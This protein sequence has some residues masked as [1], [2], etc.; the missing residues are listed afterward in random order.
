MKKSVLRTI[1]ACLSTGLLISC[2]GENSGGGDDEGLTDNQ[3][4]NTYIANNMSNYYYWNDEVTIPSTIPDDDPSEFFEELVYSGD[5]FSWLRNE[6]SGSTKASRDSNSYLPDKYTD[7]FGYGL[8]YARFT[9]GTYFAIVAYVYKDSPAEAA[10]LQRGDC[11]LFIDG[12]SITDSN[13]QLLTTASTLTL[14]LGT[15]NESD[16]TIY[17]D[18]DDIV[19]LTTESMYLDPVIC[20]TVLVKNNHRIAYLAYVDFDY[21]SSDRLDEVMA[22]FQTQ[23]ITDFVLDLRFNTGGY[24]NVMTHLCSLLAPSNVVSNSSLLMK[25]TYNEVYTSYLERTNIDMNTYFD[26]SVSYNLNLD[27]IYI[28]ANYMTASASESTIIGLAPYMEVV[29]VGENTYGKCYGGSNLYPSQYNSSWSDLDNWSMYCI[30]YKFANANDYTDFTDG[31][32]PDIE[33]ETDI[34]TAALGDESD[35]HLA[36]ALSDITGVSTT[37]SAV[38]ATRGNLPARSLKAAGIEKELLTPQQR[39]GIIEITPDIIP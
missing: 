1:L 39:Q 34:E 24:T 21:Y 17:Y 22:E 26:S 38:K 2:S 10:G 35:K 7:S 9:D 32:E 25:H 13:Y 14:T 3:R 18:P 8:Y 20:D 6:D 30:M 11:I 4:V 29:Q 27:K 31:I 36:A 19:T 37:S 16:R 33:V 5:A 15:Y 23:G 12:E 28:L